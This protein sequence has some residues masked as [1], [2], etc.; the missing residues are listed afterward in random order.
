MGNE[1]SSHSKDSR[2]RPPR[3]LK[4]DHQPSRST[5]VESPM[6]QERVEPV[7]SAQ[8][9]QAEN[10]ER[11]ESTESVEIEESPHLALLLAIKEAMLSGRPESQ[12]EHAAIAVLSNVDEITQNSSNDQETKENVAKFIKVFTIVGLPKIFMNEFKKAS[13]L[14]TE[15]SITETPVSLFKT[16]GILVE[17]FRLLSSTGKPEWV[18][19]M[20]ENNG[21]EV[22]SVLIHI[23]K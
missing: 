6:S 11:P 1:N 16:V 7:V 10:N 19:E 12:V 13:N 18:K 8:I 15:R 4:N 23:L 2:N 22:A 3:S 14:L 5:S 21:K 9:V 20:D 17:M